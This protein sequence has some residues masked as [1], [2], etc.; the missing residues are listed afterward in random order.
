MNLKVLS[1]AALTSILAPTSA[2]AVTLSLQSPPSVFNGGGHWGVSDI[3]NRPGVTAQAGGFRLTDG[4]TDFIM[5][6]LDVSHNLSTGIPG[7]YT[8][9]PTPYASSVLLSNTQIA[10][11]D[12]LFEINYSTLDVTGGFG[13]STGDTESA[14]FQMAL[15]ELVYETVGSFDVTSGAWSADSDQDVLDFA[16]GILSTLNTGIHTAAYSLVFY[17]SDEGGQN[18]VTVIPGEPGPPPVPIPAAGWLLGTSVLVLYGIAR[19]RKSPP[20]S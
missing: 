3:S 18:L 17:E 8:I 2:F 7:P 13:L 9:T 16:N 20:A 12:S 11:I 15:W 1:I 6:C 10:Q 19:R 4:V 14:G 5:W